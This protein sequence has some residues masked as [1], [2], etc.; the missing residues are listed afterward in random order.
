MVR[1]FNF[2]SVSI[3]S[4]SFFSLSFSLSLLPTCL[5]R[6]FVVETQKQINKFD[7]ELKNVSEELK[8]YVPVYFIDVIF[9]PSFFSFHFENSF[10]SSRLQNTHLSIYFNIM[11]ANEK[12]RGMRSE[13]FFITQRTLIKLSVDNESGLKEK[14][15]I[16]E[17]EKAEDVE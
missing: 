13:K 8:H 11:Q 3:F 1:L 17:M 9:P 4:S 15:S 7:I 6:Q 14:E 5:L 2:K 12:M 16:F 10:H